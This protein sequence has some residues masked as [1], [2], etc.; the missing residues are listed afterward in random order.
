MAKQSKP[1]FT[2]KEQIFIDKYLEYGNATKAAIAAGYKE[3]TATVQGSRL[4]TK[5]K[6]KDEIDRRQ[7]ILENKRIASA[8]EVM[9]FFTRAMN[10]EIKDQFGLEA[11]LGDRIKAGQELAKRTVDLE[12]RL[13]G[14]EDANVNIKIDWKRE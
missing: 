10:G 6:L 11:S 7:K 2:Q 13:A 9:E 3:T 12:N 4:L 5:V 14:K 8:A 1:R